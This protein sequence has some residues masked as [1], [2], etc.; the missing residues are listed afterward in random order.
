MVLA[1]VEKE[2]GEVGGDGCV[3]VL[4]GGENSEEASVTTVEAHDG[5]DDGVRVGVGWLG[6]GGGV[7][8][9]CG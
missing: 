8:H 9:C 2:G 6:A 4:V 5:G 3:G 7:T 1:V